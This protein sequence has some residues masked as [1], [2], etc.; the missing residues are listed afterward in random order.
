MKGKVDQEKS[1]RKCGY[2]IKN[3]RRDSKATDENE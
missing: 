2:K 3:L 1:T